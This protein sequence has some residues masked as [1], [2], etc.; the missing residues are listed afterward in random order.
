MKR[1]FMTIMAVI[2]MVNLTSCKGA[3]SNEQTQ[4]SKERFDINIATNILNSYMGYLYNGDVQRAKDLYSK[5]LSEK[6]IEPYATDVKI[7]G[8]KID[9]V[10]EVGRSAVFKV[11]LVRGASNKVISVL[12]NYNIK[13]ELKDNEYKITEISTDTEKEAFL[14]GEG[15][16]LK[17][18]NN[19]K[20]NLVVDMSGIPYY[21]FPKDDVAMINKVPVPRSSF[22]MILFSY[23]G[24][25]I[26]VTTKDDKNI[27]LGI[28]KI[29]STGTMQGSG[30]GAGTDS[31]SVSNGGGGNGG[32]GGGS[33]LIIKEPPI[34]KEI[35]S[36]DILDN[37]TI[38][39]IAFSLEEKVIMAQYKIAGKG[40]TLRV[41][42]VESG[43]L[44]DFKF[45]EKFPIDKVDLAFSSFNK[46]ALNFEVK[47]KEGTGKDVVDL[48]GKWQLDLKKFKVKKL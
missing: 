26:A 45:E 14:E 18:K 8:F 44:V 3:K 25:R 4:E 15:I 19:V 40:T 38:E 6:G 37:T 43:E 46:E 23:N 9:E 33:S 29:D 42:D 27:Y 5:E 22:G 13:I 41:Y 24:E 17:D 47:E 35:K 34:G 36:L 16:R 48:L 10:N 7:L 11:K 32:S 12:D 30:G 21:A 2:I 1:I 31:G 20:S 28:I 39:N